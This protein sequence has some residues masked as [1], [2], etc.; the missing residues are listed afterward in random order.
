MDIN[1][2]L[3][4]LLIFCGFLGLLGQ[5]L[6]VLVGI[7]KQIEAHKN[8]EPKN[9]SWFNLSELIISLIISI[10]VGMIAG[11]ALTAT[12][13]TSVDI[14]SMN[15]SFFLAIIASGYGGTDFIEGFLKKY[16]EKI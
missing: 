6:R 5:M 9:Y 8:D 12:N 13:I 15:T 16:S 11:L 10:P 3:I 7:K 4:V 2:N 1:A 14:S